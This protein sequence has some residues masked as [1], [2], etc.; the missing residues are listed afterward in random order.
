M[1]LLDTCVVS[2]ATK[3]K[4]DA[5]VTAWIAA[6]NPDT[7]YLSTVSLGE[8][9]YGVSRM[10]S[11]KRRATLLEWLGELTTRFAGRLIVLDDISAIQWG[12]LRAATNNAP[13]VDTQIAATALAYRFTLV[14]RNE[15]DFAF[16]G[17]TVLNPWKA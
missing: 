14:T 6:Q 1:F 5:G 13:V 16:D 4:P 10:S 15:K 11:G 9:H 12:K 2:E 3:P 17:L 8:L 7:L